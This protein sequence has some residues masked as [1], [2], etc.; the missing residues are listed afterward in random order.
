MRFLSKIIKKQRGSVLAE[1]AII[2]PLIIFLTFGCFQLAF[3]FVADSVMEYAA[4]CAARTYI[5]QI[6]NTED[7][8]QN[9]SENAGQSAHKAASMVTSLIS[10]FNEQNEGISVPGI[11]ELSYSSYSVNHTE[12]EILADGQ[13]AGTT[14]GQDSFSIV[15]DPDEI[16][17]IVH[18]DY[19]PMFPALTLP[20][21]AITDSVVET[22]AQGQIH[23]KKS[24]KMVTTL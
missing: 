4:F 11:G 16:E 2:L 24:C 1:F 6:T 19:R 8:L 15:N 18:F 21:L 10:F 17:I 7:G 20:G 12:I 23:L 5:V 9:A 3:L 14:I 22:D 13:P